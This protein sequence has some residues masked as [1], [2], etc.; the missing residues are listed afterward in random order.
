MPRTRPGVYK[1][2]TNP[3]TYTMADTFT[4]IQRTEHDSWRVVDVVH[5]LQEACDLCAHYCDANGVAR[6][7]VL[8]YLGSHVCVE[9]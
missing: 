6:T 8:D 3:L 2:A 1:D 9:S 7:I 5:N 4:I